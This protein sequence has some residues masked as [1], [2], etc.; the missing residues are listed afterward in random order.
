VVAAQRRAGSIG[1]PTARV[2]LNVERDVD[3][4]LGAGPGHAIQGRSLRTTFWPSTMNRVVDATSVSYRSSVAG[5]KAAA[6][7]LGP[8]GLSAVL[9]NCP[10]RGL[11]DFSRRNV[12]AP[13]RG[14]RRELFL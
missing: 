7:R 14:H 12:T 6:L 10:T 1:V 9:S 13:A 5:I 4:V 11:V 3:Q 2:K 8:T